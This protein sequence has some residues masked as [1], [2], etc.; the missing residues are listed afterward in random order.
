[1]TDKPG[2]PEHVD[3]KTC[4]YCTFQ[5]PAEAAVCPH[6]TQFLLAASPRAAG[7]AGRPAGG[8]PPS[9][10]RRPYGKW[11]L[12]AVPVLL[13]LIV[14]VLVHGRW[15]GHRIRLVPDP[16]LPIEAA[17]ER[18]GDVIL[19]TVAVTNEGQDVPDLS[20]KSIGVAV[21]LVYQ[22]GRR[23]T[24]TVFPKSL[25]RGEGALLRGETGHATMETPAKGV[26]EIVLRSEVVDLA[27]AGRGL[28]RPGRR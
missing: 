11:A 26:K 5:V 4:P 16:A 18:R 2:P 9:D 19:L 13:A 6:C 10:V 23:T 17:Q 25:Y 22:D 7:G 3:F 14:L 20:L 24:R 8:T 28:I 27:A 1:M 21:E 15:S 12:A